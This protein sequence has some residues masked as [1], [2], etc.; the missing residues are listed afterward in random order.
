VVSRPAQ[1]APIL[2]GIDL[3]VFDKDGTLV[4]F[5]ALWTAWAERFARRLE[6]VVAHPVGPRLL[7][8]L[9]CDPAT[10]RVDPAGP[11][12]LAPASELR[13][14][15]AGVVTAD[16]GLSPAAAE[17]AVAAA[18][19]LPDP[20]ADARP[21]TDLRRLFAALRAGGRRVAVVTTDD[22][23]PTE[24]TLAALGV[25]DLVAGLVAAD[26]PIPP[27]PAPDPVLHL[28]RLLDVPLARVAVVG[29]SPVDLRM[30]RAAGV[31]LVVGVL[32]G[33]GR[34]EDL[35]PLA[36]LLLPSVDAF[37]VPGG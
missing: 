22:R 24:A 34:H 18:W 1:A 29:D 32:S 7:A 31:G 9:G 14:L 20:V 6:A 16:A 19:L 2:A 25:A 12:A 11:L 4:D 37:L 33:L 26:D 10:R 8:V 15:A 17:E 3:V 21:L 30:G 27:K 35:A 23:Q 36:D 28:A 13:R 5:H